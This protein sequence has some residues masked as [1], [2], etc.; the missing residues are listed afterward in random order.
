MEIVSEPSQQPGGSLT[1][2]RRVK[3]ELAEMRGKIV[4]EHAI[5]SAKTP[6]DQRKAERSAAEV[7]RNAELQGSRFWQCG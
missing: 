6:D 3:N 4:V 1:Q 7:D 2:K 5:R